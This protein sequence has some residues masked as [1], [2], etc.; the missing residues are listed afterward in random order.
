MDISK[1]LGRV[2]GSSTSNSITLQSN[3]NGSGN[4]D[5][6][7]VNASARTSSN[8]ISVSRPQFTSPTVS[9]YGTLQGIYGVAY[10][11]RVLCGT[12]TVEVTGGNGYKL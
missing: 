5:V 12:T 2:S 4:V 6:K 9:N 8:T 11:N 3:L 7:A 10:F 1:W